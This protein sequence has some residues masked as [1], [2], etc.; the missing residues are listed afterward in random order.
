M[1]NW[2]KKLYNAVTIIVAVVTLAVTVY[3]M[4]NRIGLVDELDFGAGAYYY[5]DIPDFDKMTAGSKYVTVV[6]YWVHTVLFL[7][8]G[9]LM[10]RLWVWVDSRK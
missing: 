9:F 5:A 6:P 7:G 2:K 3:I 10:Y 4:V 1:A 8:W